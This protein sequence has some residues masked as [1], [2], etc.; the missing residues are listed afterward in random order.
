MERRE[1]PG[2]SDVGA[3]RTVTRSAARLA[4]HAHPSDAGVRR[5]PALHMDA[6]AGGTF[7]PPAASAFSWPGRS[8]EDV[9]ARNVLFMF[10]WGNIVNLQRLG[11]EAET[12]FL[13]R[14][15][16]SVVN[17]WSALT[18]HRTARSMRRMPRPAFP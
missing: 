3:L 16:A 1:A 18:T 12:G 6:A 11:R 8:E 4:R 15:R 7:S 2:T 5:L 17:L 9:L 13:I 14:I 10:Y